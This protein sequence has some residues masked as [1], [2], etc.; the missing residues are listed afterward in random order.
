LDVPKSRF[1]VDLSG[2]SGATSACGLVGIRVRAARKQDDE[3]LDAVGGS[4]QE[5]IDG[6]PGF[7][8]AIRFFVVML[9]EPL[10]EFLS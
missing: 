10:A 1:K 5:K 6:S 7:W 8:T 3:S 2:A 9:N 4:C